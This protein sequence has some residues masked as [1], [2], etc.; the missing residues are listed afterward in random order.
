M[1]DSRFA[2]DMVVLR[3]RSGSLS[4]RQQHHRVVI[5]SRG[6]RWDR[7]RAGRGRPVAEWTSS[8]PTRWRTGRGRSGWPGS[9]KPPGRLG[10]HRETRARPARAVA[11][12]EAASGPDHPEVAI[13]LSNLG[14]GHPRPGPPHRGPPTAG[15][16]RDHGRS[17]LRPTPPGRHRPPGEPRRRAP[18]PE[19]AP[20]SR[21]AGTAGQVL[22]ATETPGSG[23]PGAWSRS[24]RRV[25]PTRRPRG[26]GGP[27]G[28]SCRRPTSG[29][30]R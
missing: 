30:L 4:S 12:Q 24:G 18:R 23:P 17:R 5:R 14:P 13:R 8:S 1:C 6:T 7:L 16:S 29:S 22:T 10:H 11:I 27:C 26:R 2:P 28:G 19:P 21:T 3:D 9:S 25:R 20:R 15:T